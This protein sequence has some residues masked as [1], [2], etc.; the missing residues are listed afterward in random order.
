VRLSLNVLARLL[1]EQEAHEDGKDKDDVSE[2]D[3]D[4]TMEPLYAYYDI[5][6]LS[7]EEVRDWIRKLA[8]ELGYGEEDDY[9]AIGDLSDEEVRDWIRKLAIELEYGEEDD[10]DIAA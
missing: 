8:K 1:A 5:G 9:Y 6:K 4:H 7:D 2:T 10:L 3:I